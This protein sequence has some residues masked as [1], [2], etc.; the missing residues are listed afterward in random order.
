VSH[1]TKRQIRPVVE[2]G[3]KIAGIGFVPA[4]A[5]PALRRRLRPTVAS[6]DAHLQTPPEHARS[7]F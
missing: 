3:F 6:G 1:R 4:G 5:R 7:R 2:H